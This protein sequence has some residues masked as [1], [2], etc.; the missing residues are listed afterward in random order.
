MDSFVKR[1]GPVTLF[2]PLICNVLGEVLKEE[3]N[4]GNEGGKVVHSTPICNATILR[5]ICKICKYRAYLHVNC[6]LV[7]L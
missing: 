2:K 6:F 5:G 1:E 3:T 4:L 7:L